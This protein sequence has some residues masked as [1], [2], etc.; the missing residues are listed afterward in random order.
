MEL[1]INVLI[2]L[3]VL[4][5]YLAHIK[6]ILNFHFDKISTKRLFIPPHFLLPF[7]SHLYHP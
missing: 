3:Q 6:R 7:M 2:S 4:S 1:I 5:Q